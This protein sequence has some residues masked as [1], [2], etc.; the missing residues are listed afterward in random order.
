MM[1][2][3]IALGEVLIDFTPAGR[4]E[5]GRMLYECNPGGAPDRKSVV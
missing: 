4:S 5:R 3:V 2:K 1:A